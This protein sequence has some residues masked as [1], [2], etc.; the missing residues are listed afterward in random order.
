MLLLLHV[1]ILILTLILL[2]MILLRSNPTSRKRQL[3]PNL[4]RRVLLPTPKHVRLG[5]VRKLQ[6]VHVH[7]RPERN[8]PNQGVF[9]QQTQRLRQTRFQT[10]QLFIRH[11]HV[12]QKQI[13]RRRRD[14][15]RVDRVINHEII[16][17]Q[18]RG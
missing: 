17:K 7:V 4:R 16:R 9:R 14:L 11:A 10:R 3:I 8:Q 18:L 1:W 2:L 12:H 6:L 5:T 15:V 13:R